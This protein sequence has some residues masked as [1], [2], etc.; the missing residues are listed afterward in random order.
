MNFQIQ[1]THLARYLL[2]TARNMIPTSLLVLLGRLAIALSDR[3]IDLCQWFARMW[4]ILRIY[5]VNRQMANSR[6]AS[7]VVAAFANDG[8]A[9]GISA[10]VGTCVATCIDITA[11]VWDFYDKD[12]FLTTASLDRWLQKFGPVP[13]YVT[14]V[15]TRD[16][17]LHASTID[18]QNDSEHTLGYGLPDA[19]LVLDTLP[20]RMIKL[21][22]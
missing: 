10:C 8:D 21:I 16:G 7:R 18:I 22:P 14:I 3:Y 13:A 4:V 17:I 9:F 6:R 12:P 11:I 2:I 19:G 5:W 20:A 1:K 15:F